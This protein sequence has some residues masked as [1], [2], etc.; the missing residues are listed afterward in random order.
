MSREQELGRKSHLE[1]AWKAAY[2]VLSMCVHWSILKHSLQNR[3]TR[4]CWLTESF[5]WTTNGYTKKNK[6][7]SH[8]GVASKHWTMEFCWSFF[9]IFYFF[10]VEIINYTILFA[11]TGKCHPH[12]PLLTC[13]RVVESP[14][15]LHIHLIC[16][17]WK[18]N[19]ARTTSQD[20]NLVHR[21]TYHLFC[22][23][24]FF[25]FLFWLWFGLWCV[26]FWTAAKFYQLPNNTDRHLLLKKKPLCIRLLEHLIPWALFHGTTNISFNF[27]QDQI[28]TNKRLIK[29]WLENTI[30]MCFF[31]CFLRLYVQYKCNAYCLWTFFCITYNRKTKTK[32]KKEYGGK[33]FLDFQIFF[34]CFQLSELLHYTNKWRNKET[35]KTRTS[36]GNKE[37]N[38]R[39]KKGVSIK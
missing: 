29:K 3:Y 37:K 2:E 4:Q 39:V 11:Q 23:F 35:E 25:F 13:L 18:K 26:K 8:S 33:I 6:L 7:L 1:S 31:L 15:Y 10:Q 5:S 27:I 36:K 24:S 16:L 38:D 14:W 34:C 19:N 17:Q 32:K 12:A 30:T 28:Y 9:F 22:T 21:P 20:Q